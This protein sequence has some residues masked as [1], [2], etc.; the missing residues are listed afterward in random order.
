MNGFKTSIEIEI[1]PD[2]ADKRNYNVSFNKINTELEFECVT[3]IQQGVSEIY[4][5]LKENK[6]DSGI[7]TVTVQWYKNIIESQKLIRDIRLNDRIL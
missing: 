4:N 5:A 3:N 1:A 7:K 2:D 6:V